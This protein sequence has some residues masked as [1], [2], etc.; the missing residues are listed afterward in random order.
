[1]LATQERKVLVPGVKGKGFTAQSTILERPVLI[2][3]I[4]GTKEF[5]DR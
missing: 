2:T 1:M 4:E 3:Q 5:K